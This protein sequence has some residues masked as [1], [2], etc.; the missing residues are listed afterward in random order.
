MRSPILKPG[1]ALPVAVCA[2][3]LSLTSASPQVLAE[4]EKLPSARSIIDKHIKAI[5]GTQAILAH[6]S[7]HEVGTVTMPAAGITGKLESFSSKPNK[8]VRRMTMPGIGEVEEGFDGTIGW[9]LSPLTGPAL[10]EGKQ[11]EQL[12]FDADFYEELKANDRYTSMTTLEKTTFD[13][14][15]A[16]K[17]QLVTKHGE[18]DIEFYDTETGLKIG[19]MA[20]RESPMGP[21]QGTTVASDY[22][23]FGNLR[24]PSML[25]VSMMQVEMVMTIVTIDYDKVDPSVF[26]APPQIKALVK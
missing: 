7:T 24:Q 23:L 13:G 1:F 18:E 8:F 9:S 21:I 19:A 20:R 6:S 5:G 14:K 15:S 26:V 4:Q 12:G 16:Y 11:L 2:A 10:I 22:K 3:L 25:K 17:V